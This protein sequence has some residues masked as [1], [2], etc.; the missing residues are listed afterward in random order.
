MRLQAAWLGV[1]A[2]LVG[3]SIEIPTASAA[4]R[5]TDDPGGRIVTYMRKFAGLRESGERV[6]IDGTCASA[7]TIVLGAVPRERICITPRARLGFHAAWEFGQAGRPVTNPMATQ[8]LLAMYPP[9]VRSWI[10]RRGGLNGKMIY[11]GGREL[12]AMYPRCGTE[13]ATAG[14]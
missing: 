3:I 6:I 1:L 11:L 14:Y 10:R 5:I 12:A 9:S 4:M 8:F 2:T 13:T 7:C